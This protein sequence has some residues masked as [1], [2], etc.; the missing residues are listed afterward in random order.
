MLKKLFIFLGLVH[1]ACSHFSV[2]HANETPQLPIGMNVGSYNYYTP[3]TIFKDVMKSASHWITF[4]LSKSS[5]WNTKKSDRLELDEQGYPLEIPAIMQDG[6]PQGVRFLI[7]SNYKGRFRF[8]YDGEGDFRFK[9]PTV[10]ENGQI[11]IILDGKGKNKWIEILRS[12]RGNHI[13]NIR[14]LPED[15]SENSDDHPFHPLFLEGLKPFHCLRFMDWMRTNGSV[16]TT[17]GTRSKTNYYSQGLR[18]G[19]AIEY[20]IQLCNLLKCDAWFCIPHKADDDYIRKFAILVRDTLDPS[21]KVYLEYSNE[22]WNWMF[23][24]SHYVLEN[25][26]GAKDQYV[27]D[28]LKKIHPETKSHPEKDA[29]MMQR[30]LGIWKE[31]F[32]EEHNHRLVRVAAVQHSWHDNTRRILTYLFKRD[33]YGNSVSGGKYV[34]S[35]GEGCDAVSPAA[36]F[37]YIKDDHDRWID[38]DPDQVT[39]EMI[40]DAVEKRYDKRSGLWTDRTA[41]YVNGWNVDYIVYEG[42]QHM[43]PFKQKEWDYNHA[44]WDAQI[45]PIIYDMYMKLFR[46]LTSSEVNCKL[47]CAFSYVSKRKSRWGSWGHLENLDQILDMKNIGKVAPK[48]VALIDANTPK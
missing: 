3:Q 1:I 30:V 34:T 5:Q 28:D 48:Y 45:H 11:F 47:F 21:L 40:L 44:I 46:N 23:S 25:A 8:L 39:P 43:Q 41:K 18:K 13:R 9:V 15:Q 33:Q 27:I 6:P 37:S 19:I 20:A 31:I 42:G 32:G 36:Y 4:N 2:V 17:W 24:Q 29:Y 35:T 7:N 22:I 26:P 10:K 14:I 12:K 38:M 16:Q